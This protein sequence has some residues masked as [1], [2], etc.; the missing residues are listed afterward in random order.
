MT[1]LEKLKPEYSSIFEKN[2][3]KYP[4]LVARITNCFEQLE[5][6]SEIPF[7][8]WMDIKFFTNVY[9]PYELFT[10]NI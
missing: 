6:V 2:N 5:Y 4:E 10:D 9:S 3:L 1:L 7:G 8:I